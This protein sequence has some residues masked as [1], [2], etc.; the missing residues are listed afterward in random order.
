MLFMSYVLK[1]CLLTL[2]SCN[3]SGWVPTW[4]I[5]LLLLYVMQT[6]QYLCTN[7]HGVHYLDHNGGT[8]IKAVS[9]PHVLLLQIPSAFLVSP[10]AEVM[11]TCDLWLDIFLRCVI[12]F[13]GFMM[14]HIYDISMLCLIIFKSISRYA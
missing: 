7:V 9:S 10:M 1:L 3:V 6:M 11:Q 4:Q 8:R 13:Y 14:R 5:N 2:P 12:L